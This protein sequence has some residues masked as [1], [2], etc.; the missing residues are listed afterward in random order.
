MGNTTPQFYKL[1]SLFGYSRSDKYRFVLRDYVL[2]EIP[3]YD[4]GH[5]SF[6]DQ[7]Q[8]LR[9]VTDGNK[10]LITTNY[11]WDGCSPCVKVWDKF[12]GTPT[13][14]STVLASLVHDC[15]CQFLSSS[16]LSKKINKKD[17]DD[18]FHG[19]MLQN[20]FKYADVYFEAVRIFG[21]VYHALGN[22]K[23]NPIS[24]E[25]N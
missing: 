13:P 7:K 3:N 9:L 14:E 25:Q 15:L 6:Y 10:I 5:A 21:G 22:W 12:I 4:F 18:I 17:V 11:A 23:R 20:R 8:K 16:C 2:I 1:L 24:C 19:I